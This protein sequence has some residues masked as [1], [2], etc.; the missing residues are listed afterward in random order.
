MQSTKAALRK[1]KNDFAESLYKDLSDW[2]GNYWDDFFYVVICIFILFAAIVVIDFIIKNILL[3]FTRGIVN[4]TKFKWDNSF[5]KHKVFNSIYHLFPIAMVRSMAP[6]LFYDKPLVLEYVYKSLDILLVLVFVQMFLRII[7]SISDISTDENNYRTVAIRTFGQL[8]KVILIFLATLVIIS[9]LFN[10]DW[11]SILAGLGATTAILLLIFRDTILGFVSGVQIASTRMVKV[12]DWVGVPKYNLEGTVTEIN[13]V[14]AKI[15]E[16]DKTISTIP[17]YDFISTQIRNFES[18]RSTHTRRIKRSIVFNV[19]S[20]S[21]LTKEQLD[22]FKE[23]NLLRD[24]ISTKEKEIYTESDM[25]PTQSKI[26]LNGRRLTNIGL[27]REY[28]YQ[29]LLND[30]KVSHKEGDALMVRQLD[31]TPQGMP[32][33]IYCFANT[34]IWEEY[35]AIQSDIFDHLVTSSKEFGLEVSQVLSI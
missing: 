4:A 33:E 14:S 26:G 19:K 28:A 16:F 29:Y 34:T 32:M 8:M 21:F 27:F 22:K 13:L 25:A 5:Y 17:T 6:Y 12:G 3:R 24:Y 31:I 23:V 18:M 9:I 7:N 11:K 30:P 10:V 15:R 20:F 2:V 35:E 1:Y